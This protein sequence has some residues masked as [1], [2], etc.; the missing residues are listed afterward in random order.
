MV[1]QQPSDDGEIEPLVAQADLEKPACQGFDGEAGPGE[2]IGGLDMI[3]DSDA[4]RELSVCGEDVADVA[5]GEQPA[6]ANDGDRVGDLLHLAE[7]VA[8][9]KHGLSA[10]S[11]VPHHAANLVNAGRVKPIGR[12]VEDEQVR[13]LEQ[14]CRDGEPLFHAE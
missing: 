5:F 6:T 12:L 4:S 1:G 9:D 10:P 3:G 8:G 14:R 13:I 7:N 11:Q 2:H